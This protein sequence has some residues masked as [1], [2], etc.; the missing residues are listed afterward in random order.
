MNRNFVLVAL[1]AGGLYFAQK[2]QAGIARV[3]VTGRQLKNISI[4]LTQV[5]I[6][7]DIY[8]TSYTS[9]PVDLQGVNGIIVYN[10]TAIGDINSVQP[11]TIQQGVNT[12]PV[13]ATISTISAITT[14]LPYFQA[15]QKKEP[16]PPGVNLSASG[17]MFVGQAINVPF[18][19][20]LV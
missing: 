10:N 7:I 20:R 18:Q 11:V 6:N 4:Q 15:L 2:L 12:I 19:F 5:T 13:R 14:L 17:N 9:T 3:I 1:V 16:L 8:V